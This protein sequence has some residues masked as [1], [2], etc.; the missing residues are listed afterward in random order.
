MIFC[1]FLEICIISLG[2]SLSCSIF[3]ASFV[4]VSELFCG[5]LLE[6]FVILSAFYCQL[7]HHLLQLFFWIAL[8]KTVL[9]ATVA[10]CLAWS[11][12]FW[13][14]LLLIILLMFLPMLL[15]MFFIKRQKFIT[16][17]NIWC[18]NWMNWIMSHFCMLH[19]N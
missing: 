2:I 3:S 4:T 13:L 19:F 6:T 1:L 7:N 12:S 18:L 14:Y 9:S 10:H 17:T 11:R 5:K 15:I 16:F 8:Y